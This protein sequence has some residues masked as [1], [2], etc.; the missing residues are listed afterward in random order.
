[1]SY[2]PFDFDLEKIEGLPE[3]QKVAVL[4]QIAVVQERVKQNPLWRYKP[5][6]GEY[7]R[8]LEAGERLTGEESR[9]QVE[10]H[11]LNQRL[12]A[13][14]PTGA[15]VAGNRFGKSHAGAT[16]NLIQTLPPEFVPPWLEVYRRRPYNGDYRC[17]IV[18]PDE[19]QALKKVWLP[20][21][22]KLIPQGALYGGSFEKAWNSKDRQLRF[23]DE[24]W[25]DFLTHNMPVDAFAGAD[26]DRVHF[27]EEPPGELGRQQFDESL[28]RLVDRDGDVRF[29]MTPLFGFSWLFYELTRADVPR[30]DE[31]V[32]VV[33]GSIDDNP[34]LPQNTVTTLVARW[35]ARDPGRADA[36]RNGRFVHFAGLIFP[37]F[38]DTAPPEGHV[39]PPREIPRNSSDGKPLVP[40]YAAIDPGIDHPAGL[41]F[42]WLSHTDVA[43]VFFAEKW[44]D[45][46]VDDLASIYWSVCDVNRFRP[47]WTVIDPSAQ[48]RNFQTGRNI[49]D[50]LAREHGINCIPGNN[51]VAPGLNEIR[52]R[53]ASQR[54]VIHAD[55]DQLVDEIRTYRW[56]NKARQSED[57]PKLEPVKKNDDLLDPLR[58][59][60]M[61]LPQA[62]KD[63][64]DQ[65]H[66]PM[67][68]LLRDDLKRLARRR[69]GRRMSGSTHA[70]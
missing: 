52:E 58:Y 35:H 16:D 43:E 23:A 19:P 55:Q 37:E 70:R 36:R 46:N 11:E 48:N 21:L 14:I 68:K 12:T 57:E 25:W 38:R 30:Q 5:H 41:V 61:S 22:R 66:D 33:Q 7:G 8:K 28:A 17:R 44:R 51:K 47:R 4:R 27:D 32:Y 18:V 60:L 34:S 1:M 15:V 42:F 63:P 50:V 26:V 24:S 6:A 45:L 53:L 69:K 54:L 31:E 49:Q 65:D 2:A 67:R 3:E 59:G 20:K 39:A 62:G 64:A 13:P 29:T 40:I 56:K 10:F 9:G